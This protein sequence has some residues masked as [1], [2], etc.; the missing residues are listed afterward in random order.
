MK[1]IKNFSSDLLTELNKF[2]HENLLFWQKLMLCA[3]NRWDYCAA[4]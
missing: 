2:G 3:V 1:L 4:K